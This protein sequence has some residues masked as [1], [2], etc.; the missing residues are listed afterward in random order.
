MGK[1]A[2]QNV[3]YESNETAR[4]CLILHLLITWPHFYVL[5]TLRLHELISLIQF[6]LGK[7]ITHPPVF[8]AQNQKAWT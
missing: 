5:H 4:Q 6:Y 8:L 1:E 7:N 2:M 3:V